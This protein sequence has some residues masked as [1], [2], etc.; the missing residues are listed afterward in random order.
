MT[1]GRRQLPDRRL[2]PA[3]WAFSCRNLALSLEALGDW[4]RV[5]ELH[6]EARQTGASESDAVYMQIEWEGT[7]ACACGD[8][9][10]AVQRLGDLRALAIHD[11]WYLW[12]LRTTHLEAQIAIGR[13]DHPAARDLLLPL[14]SP[15]HASYLGEYWPAALTAATV[16]ADRYSA[17]SGTDPEDLEALRTITELVEQLPRVGSYNAAR[18]R[19]ATAALAQAQG[20]D[21]PEMWE[22]V[23][24]AWRTLEHKPLLGW[25]LLRLAH[26]DAQSGDKTAAADPLAEAWEIAQRLGATPLSERVTG[27][28]QRAHLRFS[29]TSSPDTS[30]TGSLARLTNRELEVLKHV[31][32]GETND[33]IGTALFIS[34][35]TVSVHVSNILAKLEVT[36]RTKATAIAYEHGLLSDA[37]D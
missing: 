8:L 27:L 4:E 32:L 3:Y 35:K 34:P 19:H 14:M 22:E 37:P 23:A 18:Y 5:K 9:G 20:T 10:T 29:P 13:G 25:A 30:A 6:Q 21:T 1:A 7:F 16:Q 2:Y 26:A 28:A 31:A 33:E 36:S 24:A 12:V 11:T 17:H 15:A